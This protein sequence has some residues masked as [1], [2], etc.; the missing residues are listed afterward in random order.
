MMANDMLGDCTIAAVAHAVQVWTA[1]TGSPVT[2]ADSV[3]VNY[4]SL[5]DGYVPGDPATD[6][7]GVETDVL[8]KWRKDPD[9]FHGYKLLAY[10]DPD[11][12]NRDHIKQ[13]VVLFGGVYIGLNL[14]I[15]AQSQIGS[16]WEY[17][18][19]RPGT[20]GGHA[21]FVAGYDAEGL[22]CITWGKLQKMTWEF[23]S[24]Y[25]DE[26]HTLLSDI[27]MNSA[28]ADFHYTN[29]YNDLQALDR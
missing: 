22:T 3:V 13:S 6:Q 4:Y 15:S 21:V 17:V 18:G 16:L 7:G 19:G 1:A 12:G 25:C 8:D 5:W 20:W 24:R 29:L 2:A 14:P 27:W 23:W 11:P 26:A 10:A 9:G 28:P